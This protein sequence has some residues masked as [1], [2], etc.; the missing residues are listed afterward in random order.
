[1]ASKWRIIYGVLS[2][3]RIEQKGTSFHVMD[4]WV[5]SILWKG[6]YMEMWQWT[7][8]TAA[9][10]NQWSADDMGR[11]GGQASRWLTVPTLIL[12]A[13][14]LTTNLIHKRKI[15]PPASNNET[16]TSSNKQK[17]FHPIMWRQGIYESLPCI[18]WGP[19]IHAVVLRRNSR[20]H[21]G[22]KPES[23]HQE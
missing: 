23:K 17:N 22:H 4:F 11:G 6:F 3:M 9:E 7:G 12:P 19:Q 20:V 21:R 10:K 13:T 16:T 2:D 8:L 18:Q 5:I 1:M 14:N 15:Q